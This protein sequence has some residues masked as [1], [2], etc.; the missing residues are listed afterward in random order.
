MAI[1]TST[2]DQDYDAEDGCCLLCRK[3]FTE[4]SPAYEDDMHFGCY[5]ETREPSW[6]G[7]DG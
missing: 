6:G 4:E 3:P 1:S 2:A 7:V 5:W